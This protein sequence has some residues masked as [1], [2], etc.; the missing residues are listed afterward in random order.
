MFFYPARKIQYPR[1]TTPRIIISKIIITD[2]NCLDQVFIHFIICLYPENP[3]LVHF[4][5]IQ[6]ILDDWVK[7]KIG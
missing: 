5:V 4:L 1:I 6:N 2:R 7:S 3:V